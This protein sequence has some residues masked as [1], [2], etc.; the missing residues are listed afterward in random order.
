MEDRRMQH[1]PLILSKY[2]ISGM[3]AYQ[4]EV[5]REVQRASREVNA[6]TVSYLQ[7]RV[8]HFGI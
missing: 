5:R 8:L 1:A 3:P 4:E 6:S 2:N 7:S